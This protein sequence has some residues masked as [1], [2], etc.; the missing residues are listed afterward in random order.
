M[1]FLARQIILMCETTDVVLLPD[2]SPPNDFNTYYA[3]VG[4]SSS[5]QRITEGV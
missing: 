2:R 3:L 1:K 5:V 4:S